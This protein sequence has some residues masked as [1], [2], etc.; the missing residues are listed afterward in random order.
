M[1]VHLE[2]IRPPREPVVLTVF[3]LLGDTT[4]IVPRGMRVR[5]KVV[6]LLGDNEYRESEEPE[7]PGAPASQGAVILRGFSLLGDIVIQEEGYQKPGF[8]RSLLKR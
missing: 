8:F 7:A 1:T 6:S 4:V 5:N 2:R 3:S